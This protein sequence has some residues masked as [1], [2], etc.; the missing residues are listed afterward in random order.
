MR[1]ILLKPIKKNYKKLYAIL[2][3]DFCKSAKINTSILKKLRVTFI[4]FTKKNKV[5]G[6]C[7]L[8]IS[9][10]R[11]NELFIAI[12]KKIRGKG[13]GRKLMISLI[14][15]CKRKKIYFF[16]QSFNIKAYHPALSLYS[17]LGF[18]KSFSI[19]DKIILIKKNYPVLIVIY[20][21]MFFYYSSMKLLIQKS[22]LDKLRS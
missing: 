9:K 17:S 8:Y 16:I 5:E 11:T 15:W 7:G 12:N 2:D 20:R 14:A 22:L 3:S 4:L 21:I 18:N 13:Y 19:G 6:I 10:Y 1:I